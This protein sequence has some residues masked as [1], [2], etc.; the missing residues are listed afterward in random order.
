VTR[1]ILF[2]LVAVVAACSKSNQPPSVSADGKLAISVTKNGFEPEDIKVA[3]GKPVT[4][5][6][7]RKTDDTCAKDI[8]I[9]VDD[10]QTIE[11]DLPLNQAVEVAV[12]FPTAGDIT[13]ACGM[14]MVKGHIHVN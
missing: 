6:F 2:T 7:T 10:K 4:L 14:D 1:T 9:H 5:V 8:V 11:K 3:A 13:Y 12:T